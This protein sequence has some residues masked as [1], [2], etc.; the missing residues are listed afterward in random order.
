M[1]GMSE[2]RHKESVAFRAP[3]PLLE[4]IKT[5]SNENNMSQSDALRELV[6]AGLDAEKLQEEI[7]S[8]EKRVDELENRGEEKSF[9]ERLF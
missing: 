2:R 4:R 5:Y 3:E 9:I 8:L 6:R 1:L 7:D